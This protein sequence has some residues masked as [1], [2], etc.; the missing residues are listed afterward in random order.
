MI[1]D[2]EAELETAVAF[3]LEAFRP[4][5]GQPIKMWANLDGVIP[6][7]PTVPATAVALVITTGPDA[8]AALPCITVSCTD[9]PTEFELPS[10]TEQFIMATFVGRVAVSLPGVQTNR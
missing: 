3:D 10:S 2:N 7:T 5:P 6:S 9:L 4:G 1:I 8:S